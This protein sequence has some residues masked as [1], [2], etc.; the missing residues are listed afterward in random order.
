M[1]GNNQVINVIGWEVRVSCLSSPTIHVKASIFLQRHLSCLLYRYIFLKDWWHL[2]RLFYK[3]LY[4]GFEVGKKK[5]WKRKEGSPFSRFY[6]Q[7]K[8]LQ[9]NLVKGTKVAS[10]PPGELLGSL[11]FLAR[12][13]WQCFIPQ[14]K[15]LLRPGEVSVFEHR[16]HFCLERRI[17]CVYFFWL[18]SVLSSGRGMK[19][20]KLLI[21]VRRDS[22]N[23]PRDFVAEWF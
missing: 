13:R 2:R 5:T 14:I 9:A 4:I 17:L 15:L 16:L 8:L 18:E 3:I 12:N 1:G 11:G 6:E 10:C 21:V 20:K 19:E 23:F 22:K 7:M